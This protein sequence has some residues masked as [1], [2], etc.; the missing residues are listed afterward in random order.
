VR[1]RGLARIALSVVFVASGV[2]ARGAWAA[3]GGELVAALDAADGADVVV[4][5]LPAVAGAPRV[6]A[7]TTTRAPVAV[8]LN[9]L[10]DPARYAALIPSVVR[11]DE[12]GRRG[13]A[14][15]VKWELEIPLFNLSGTL[16]LRARPS[17][18]ELALVDGDLAPGSIVIDA[19]PRA[20]GGA[21]L[22]LDARLDVHNSSFFLRRVMARS[23]YGE[24]AALA[25]AAWVALRATALR[26]EHPADATAFRPT[27]PFA[28]STPGATDGRAL[29]RPP[30]ARLAR[31]GAVALVARAPSGRLASASVA[32]L[33]QEA[34]GALAAR[35][36]DA[37]GWTAFPGWRH[38][39]PMPATATAPATVVVEDGIPFI[40]F[41]A[42]WRA[43]PP[44]RARWWRAIDGA[45]RD[46][47][48]GWDV[49]PS[50]EAPAEA[51]LTMAPRLELTGSIPRRFIAAEPLLEHGLAL[52]L[53]FVDA[54]SATRGGP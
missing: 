31:A 30:L 43:E 14:R 11:A 42:T 4:F 22:T 50:R 10:G 27:A 29:L 8:V 35:L 53:T 45:A 23:P 39:Q 3:P 5:D 19:A 18:W 48:F 51:A 15:V 44:P 16:E 24:P 1:R 25:A 34:P 32:T 46:A 28:P 37:R 33:S 6:R 13:D 20:E 12:V 9:V 38:V 36:A 21:T 26:A 17:G 41:D 54:V 49:A 7:A 52:A 2:G 40:D 47:W